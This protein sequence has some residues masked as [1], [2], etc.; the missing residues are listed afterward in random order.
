MAGSNHIA[1]EARAASGSSA[2]VQVVPALSRLKGHG[3]HSTT[4]QSRIADTEPLHDLQMQMSPLVAG[5]LC[6][7]AYDKRMVSQNA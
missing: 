1:S 4:P 6:D 3:A 5:A 7:A 2:A